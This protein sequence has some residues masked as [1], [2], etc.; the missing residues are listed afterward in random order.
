VQE[1]DISTKKEVKQL[2]PKYLEVSDITFENSS[3]IDFTRDPVKSSLFYLQTGKSI[4]SLKFLQ[5]E[6]IKEKL[7]AS[8]ALDQYDIGNAKKKHIFTDNT[9][10]SMM[11]SSVFSTVYLLVY[12][13]PTSLTLSLSS[14]LTV[15]P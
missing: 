9:K 8:I 14:L 11:Y 3:R 12:P 5:I 15:P 6:A 2:A 10:S 4:F 1:D 13:S 7:M